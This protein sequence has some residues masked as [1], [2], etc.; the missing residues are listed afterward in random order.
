MNGDRCAWAADD[1]LMIAYHDEEWGVPIREDRGLFEFI[2][3]EGAQAGLSWRTILGRR[4]GYREA[5]DDFD[6]ERIA[7]YGDTKIETLLSDP[8][9]IRNRLKIH[10]TVGN[11]QAALEAIDEFGSLGALIWR[12]VDGER[13][14]NDFKSLEEIPAST[15]RVEE[16]SKELKRRGFRFVGP[17]ICYAFMQAAGLV[18]DH[19]VTCFRYEEV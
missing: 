10:A 11:A 18:N 14:R 4:E 19:L 1:D 17:T 12:F 15:A 13:I 8:G 2:T 3:L 5:F 9:I 7:R 16:M 6:I